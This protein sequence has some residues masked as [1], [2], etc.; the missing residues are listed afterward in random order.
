M[1]YLGPP[2]HKKKRT[3]EGDGRYSTQ[4]LLEGSG[5]MCGMY[6]YLREG[7]GRKHKTHDRIRNE[8]AT[9]AHRGPKHMVVAREHGYT[10]SNIEQA[11][12]LC[13]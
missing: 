13:T 5:I 12:G 9:T 10:E 7:T 11:D 4:F 3:H 8:N 2:K 1:H 6:G